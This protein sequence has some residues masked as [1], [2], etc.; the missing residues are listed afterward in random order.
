MKLTTRHTGILRLFGKNLKTARKRRYPSAQQFAHKLGL[1]PHT[2]RMYE[3][4]KS[5]PNFETL[6]RIC[7]E[8]GITPNELLPAASGRQRPSQAASA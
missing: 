8:L 1:E 7:E 5:E 4:G 3:R 2:Y 6:T